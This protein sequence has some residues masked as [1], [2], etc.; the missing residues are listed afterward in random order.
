MRLNVRQKFTLFG[1]RMTSMIAPS[2]GSYR[3][4]GKRHHLGFLAFNLHIP[5]MIL[6]IFY[7]N[8]A[9]YRCRPTIPDT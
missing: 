4:P 8:V 5:S 2:R 9:G 6:M 7:K 1:W 3:S